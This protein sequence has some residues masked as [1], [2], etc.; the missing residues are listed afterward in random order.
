M[1]LLPELWREGEVRATHRR[2]RLPVR[3]WLTREDPFAEIWPEVLGWLDQEPDRTGKELFA[4]LAAKHPGRFAPGQLRT[5]QRRI[6]ERR[7]TMAR[8]L[9]LPSITEPER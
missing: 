8:R 3:D 9:L 2:K 1:R 7:G 4:R 6:R 5:L